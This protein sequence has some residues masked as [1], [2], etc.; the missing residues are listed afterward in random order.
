MPNYQNICT[1]ILANLP[2]RQKEV[3]SRR[4]GINNG[5]KETLES[6]GRDFGVT[7]ERV[8]QIEADALARLEREKENRELKRV[9]SEFEDYFKKQGGI[10]REDIVLVDLGG[11]D[12]QGNVSFLLTVGDSFHYF[13][14]TEDLYPFWAIEKSLS[15]KVKEI[16]AF[17]VGIFEKEKKPLPENDF[18]QLLGQEK[19]EFFNSSVEI[20]KRIEK[21][22]L[23]HFGLIDWPEIKPRRTGDK[24]YLVLKKE[25]KPLHFRT[26][27]E[28]VNTLEG[29]T[30][31]KKEIFPQTVHNELIKDDR[32]VL[33]GRGIYALREWGYLPGT[34]KDII[35]NLLKQNE[36]GL[37]KEEIVKK[38]LEQKLVKEDTILLNLHDK[39]RFAR[40]SQGKYI[41]V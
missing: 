34:V 33:V 32:F 37:T 35:V 18:F 6:I 29:Y 9:F 27:A 8:R 21:G 7:R 40:D 19:Q 38:V 10:K 26:I 20:A 22:P 4:F 39:K 31:K 3:I 12:F 16:I 23:S 2:P 24:A 5:K 36:G 25:G 11:E 14:E 28:L 17:L 41:L 30:F 13:S 15:Q 1:T